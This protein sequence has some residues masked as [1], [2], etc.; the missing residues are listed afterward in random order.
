MNLAREI[1]LDLI[2][3]KRK[4]NIQAY[5]N[6]NLRAEALRRRAEKL[7][8][9]IEQ[10]EY[11]QGILVFDNKIFSLCDGVF[12]NTKRNNR[13]F[14][15]PADM[16]G[17]QGKGMYDFLKSKSIIVKT[18]VDVGANYGEIS[19]YFSRQDPET[20]ILAIEASPEN[21]GILKSNYDFQ[22]FPTNNLTLVNEAVSDK[23]GEMEISRGHGSENSVIFSGGEDKNVLKDKVKSD[24]LS[25]IIKRYGFSEIDFLKIDIE[26]AEPLLLQSLKEIISRVKAVIIEI[27]NNINKDEYLPLVKLF[28]ESSMIC[29]RDGEDSSNPYDKI[30]EIIS[31]S[32]EGMDLWFIRE[33]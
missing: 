17:N 2:L 9:V 5:E 7:K 1:R 16:P 11:R 14:K 3:A 13:Y 24:T 27:G 29:Y 20:K 33:K 23:A 4:N 32:K 10:V 26:G 21:F 25:S 6:R 19:L 15:V 8:D 31:N 28:F 22:F 18:M 12:L 30:K